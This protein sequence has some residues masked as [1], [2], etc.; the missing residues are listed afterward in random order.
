MKRRELF[1]GVAALLTGTALA[2]IVGAAVA[3]AVEPRSFIALNNG[4][5][6]DTYWL[7]DDGFH[8]LKGGEPTMAALDRKFKFGAFV[9][10]TNNYQPRQR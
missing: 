7:G 2:P 6:F 10:D 9:P 1:K 8:M 5:S 3:E 4:R